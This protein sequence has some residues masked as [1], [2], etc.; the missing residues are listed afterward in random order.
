MSSLSA[1]EQE[2]AVRSAALAYHLRSKEGRSEEQIAEKLGFGSAEAMHQQFGRW[3]FP[4]W[5]ARGRAGASD[6]H[7]KEPPERHKRKPRRGGGDAVDLP[8]AKE[9]EALFASALRQLE[10]EISRLWLREER[11]RD[12]RFEA[13]Y[14]HRSAGRS[15]Y[16]DVDADTD[17]EWEKLC[18]EHGADPSQEWFIVFDHGLTLPEGL[19]QHP[20]EPLTR[21]IAVYILAGMSLEPLLEKLHPGPVTADLKQQLELHIEGRKTQ[22]GHIPGLKGEAKQVARLVRGGVVRPGP[23]TGELSPREQAA[24]WHIQERR[25]QGASDADI[26][27]ELRQDG[28]TREDVSRLGNLR[29][30]APE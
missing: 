1:A 9:A 17:E 13:S 20:A 26:Y 6:D 30:Q 29:L 18:R 5:L 3:G 14:V 4:D 11:Y 2:R 27:Q 15:F 23:P 8:P 21:L 12:R 22:R 25:L 24:A 7:V 16:R 10:R 28:F 19:S